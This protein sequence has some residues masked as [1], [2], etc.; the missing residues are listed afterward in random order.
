MKGVQGNGKNVLCLIPE[1]LIAGMVAC[2]LYTKPSMRNN[3]GNRGCIGE[4]GFDPVE[5]WVMGPSCGL[6]SRRSGD[7]LHDHDSKA[8]HRIH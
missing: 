3:F 2:E 5:L 6:K 1:L 7:T 8:C 4:S